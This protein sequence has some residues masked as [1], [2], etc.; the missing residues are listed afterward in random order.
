MTATL[1]LV[2]LQ[3]RF[4]ST[5]NL[6]TTTLLLEMLAVVYIV[7]ALAYVTYGLRMYSRITSKQLGLGKKNGAAS[8]PDA[9]CV[10]GLTIESYRGLVDDCRHGLLPVCVQRLCFLRTADLVQMFSIPLVSLQYFCMALIHL[11]T[12]RETAPPH[13]IIGKAPDLTRCCSR[14]QTQLCW[15]PLF[16]T[17]R[18]AKPDHIYVSLRVVESSSL[19]PYPGIGQSIDTRFHVED[20]RAHEERQ[21]DHLCEW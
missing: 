4:S 18:R 2:P 14:L 1:D 13:Y 10:E 9:F 20:L 15:S 5:S 8:D 7:S 12:P 6:P 21:A 16:G 3:A 19:Q 11:R 17:A